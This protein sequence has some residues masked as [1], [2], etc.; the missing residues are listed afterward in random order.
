LPSVIE[1]VPEL[2]KTI[3]DSGLSIWKAFHDSSKERRDAI[4]SEVDQLRWRSF[5]DLGKT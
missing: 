1:A 2:V 3:T 5:A 4:L